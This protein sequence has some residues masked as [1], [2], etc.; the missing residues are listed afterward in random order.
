MIDEDV[1]VYETSE[2]FLRHLLLL[3][4]LKI[5]RLFFSV[6]EFRVLALTSLTT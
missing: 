6:R 4:L 1:K 2:V 5:Y 3:L